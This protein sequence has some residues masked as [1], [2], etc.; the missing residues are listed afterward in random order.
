MRA[1][2]KLLGA[3][4][5]ASLAFGTGVAQADVFVTATA[6]KVKTVTVDKTIYIDKFV[7][8]FANVFT[9][10][11][12]TSEQDIF[13]N[14]RNQF[15]FYEEEAGTANN[16]ILDSFGGASG[17]Q[18][19]IQNNGSNNNNLNSDSL[20]YA[21]SQS[22]SATGPGVFS[23]A[24]VNIEQLNGL[25]EEPPEEP[26]GTSMLPTDQDGRGVNV[27]ESI[28][29]STYTNNIDASY[30]GAAGVAKVIQENGSNNNNFNGVAIALGD[31]TTFAL[32]EVNAG[33]FNNFN[34]ANVRALDRANNI[35]ASF[36]TYNG[37]VA[38]IQDNGS[39][40]NNANS[41]AIS[42]SLLNPPTPG[43]SPVGGL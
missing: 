7:T 14:Q 17:E 12:G 27:F 25:F 42:A 6:D 21:N 2:I 11:D 28:E 43:S 13:A 33:Q 23:D 26:D 16:T 31:Q 34:F 38:V 3:A 9:E 37:I 29:G 8:V 39:N 32:D 10:N 4:I 19:T 40:N 24:E 30:V 36:T 1:P 22:G 15:N 5:V 35:N 18:A 20:S 41:S